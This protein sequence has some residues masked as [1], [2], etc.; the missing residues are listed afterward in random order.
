MINEII[1]IIKRFP[2]G[3]NCQPWTFEKLSENKV[4][5]HYS[6]IKAK[7]EFNNSNIVTK[8]SIGFLH[9]YLKIIT[10]A[11]GYT[12]SLK[13]SEYNITIEFKNLNTP[14]HDNTL[15]DK[16]KKRTSDR[17]SYDLEC[18]PGDIDLIK[19][20]SQA[21][22]RVYSQ[23]DVNAKSFIQKR[24]KTLWIN[25]T[26]FKD[27]IQ[28]V[29][30]SRGEYTS[31][32]DGMFYKHL[33]IKWIDTF[34]LKLLR[35]YPALAP[36]LFKTPL[37]LIVGSQIQKLYKNTGLIFYPISNYEQE[38]INIVAHKIILDWINLQDLGFSYHPMNIICIPPLDSYLFTK[39]S[40]Y[41]VEL[42]EI[43]KYFNLQDWPLWAARVGRCERDYPHEPSIRR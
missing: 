36:I 3:D 32:K 16:L 31:S 2:T 13:E 1:E 40:K 35:A 41:E 24:E 12:Y 15:L 14:S 17:R 5:L 33:N 22:L 4:Q 43:K 6:I 37:Y 30:L 42:N 25:K 9:S 28:W 29:R 27:F 20:Q 18:K 19:S 38:E 21:E 39:E 8:I 23:L 34:L 7:H 26:I 11:L 10:E